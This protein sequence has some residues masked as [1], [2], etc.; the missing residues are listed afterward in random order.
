[1]GN[2]SQAFDVSSS[3]F[4]GNRFNLTLHRSSVTS[5]VLVVLIEDTGFVLK[6]LARSHCAMLL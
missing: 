2:D 1:M 5:S 3:S 4:D 6:S